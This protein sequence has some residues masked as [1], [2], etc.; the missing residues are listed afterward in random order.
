MLPSRSLRLRPSIYSSF[1]F[2]PVRTPSQKRHFVQNLNE[3]FL[4]LALALPYPAHWPAYSATIILLTVVIRTALLPTVFWVCANVVY[5]RVCT[6][7]PPFKQATRRQFRFER[8]VLPVLR[9]LKPIVMHEQANAMRKEGLLENKELR[10]EI[11]AKRCHDIVRNDR[12]FVWAKLTMII[13][14][15][16]KQRTSEVAQVQ[17]PHNSSYACHGSSTSLCRYD[18]GICTSRC[19]SHFSF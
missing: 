17:T 11:H 12:D 2:T 10:A 9:E 14:A 19:R 4:D 5:G 15:N 6:L 1:R 16:E 18:H 13:D 3:G 7:Q 8:N